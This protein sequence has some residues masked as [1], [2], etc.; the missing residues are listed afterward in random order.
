MAKQRRSKEQRQADREQKRQ[1]KEQNKQQQAADLEK[2]KA[3]DADLK[4]KNEARKSAPKPKPIGNVVAGGPGDE[5]ETRVMHVSKDPDTGKQIN[6][7]YKSVADYTKENPSSVTSTISGN[8]PKTE[9]IHQI[10]QKQEVYNANEVKD[11]AEAVD[12]E[13]QA[14]DKEVNKGEALVNAIDNN[15]TTPETEQPRAAAEGFDNKT[16]ADY[17]AEGTGDYEL[18]DD[19]DLQEYSNQFL[20]GLAAQKAAAPAAAIEKLGIEHYYPPQQDYITSNFTG[21]YIGSRQLV[22]GTGALIPVGLLDAR[23]RAKEAK[24]AEKA[25]RTAKFWEIGATTAQYDEQYKAEGMAILEKYLDL[26]GGNIDE[27]MNG[28]SKLSMEYY[29]EMYQFQAR[30]KNLTEINTHIRDLIDK[31]NQGEAGDM[32]IPTTMY[33]KMNEFL[34]GTADMSDYISGKSMGDAQ[35]NHLTDYIRSFQNYGKHAKDWITT[36]KDQ[37]DK[38]PLRKDVDWSDP[39]TAANLEE[40]I[41]TMHTRDWEKNKVVMGQYF[42]MGRLDK[43]V[44]GIEREYRVYTGSGDPKEAEKL[45]AERVEMM[46][47]SLGKEID[48]EHW[49]IATN[50]LGWYNAN[51]AERKFDWEKKTYRDYYLTMWEAYQQDLRDQAG[52]AANA[53][54]SSDN[55][56]SRGRALHEMF[57]KG[58]SLGSQAAKEP[59][60]IGGATVTKIN[61][62]GMFTES[63]N[64]NTMSILE[65]DKAIPAN[66]YLSKLKENAEAGDK[67]AEADA[68]ELERILNMQG[69]VQHHVSAQYGGY[70]VRNKENGKLVN[71]ERASGKVS[72]D[73]LIETAYYTGT[74]GVPDI[75][76]KTGEAKRDKDHKIII[77]Q[78]KWTFMSRHIIN[79]PEF[80][81]NAPTDR[82]TPQVERH[83]MYP[84]GVGS[85]S[86][87]TGG[88]S[89]SNYNR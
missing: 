79:N 34:R 16:V 2:I 77:N 86:S 29:K 23:N 22:A 42:D 81:R 63:I 25:K 13:V 74:V 84:S 19:V 61:S 71:A 6:T 32:Y 33:D 26:S 36:V 35:L 9:T 37:P 76:P 7:Q 67:Q 80:I 68:V 65:G 70:S 48:I 60:N 66:V 50:N 27:L 17:A 78:S 11:N 64:P 43:I 41:A 59:V 1:V 12:A 31:V 87:E 8:D 55:P 18:P 53:I 47:A 52:D 40:A 57:L 62:R 56:Q 58:G 44:A 73:D 20:K 54:N 45:H 30:G 21:K 49:E 88:S 38:V 75:D 82:A 51:L 5:P 14:T 3:A 15:Q 83:K 24:A 39:Q 89:S 4:A 46:I 69:G 72:G 10:A 85:V 28:T